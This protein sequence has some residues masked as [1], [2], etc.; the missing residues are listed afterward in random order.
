MTTID[1]AIVRAPNQGERMWVAGDLHRYML[2]GEDTNGA[3]T[4]HETVVAPYSGPPPH[5]HDNEDELF[6]VLE[7]E[8]VILD[9]HRTIR[10][11]PGT[12]VYSRRGNLHTYRN[13][14]DGP[15]RLLVILAPAGFEDFARE[16]GEPVI[17]GEETPDTATDPSRIAKVAARHGIKVETQ[18]F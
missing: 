17:S 11:T 2:T 12:L 16:V 3:M 13:V 18:D 14:G 7:G 5:L 8:F 10:A 9:S 1:E 6:Y 4:V 15:G